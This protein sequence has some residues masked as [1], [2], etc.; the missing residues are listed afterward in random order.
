[1]VGETLEEAAIREVKEETGLDVEIDGVF[2]VSE[3]FFVER[4]HH[5]IFFTFRGKIIGR[6]INISMPKEIEEITWI[7]SQKAED[8]IHITNSK[9]L[10]KSKSSVPYLL[11]KEL[12]VSPNSFFMKRVL[13]FNRYC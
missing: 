12:F 8:Y 11:K 4:G 1:M 13:L 9:G 6:E 2:S 10:I 3:A 7:D 5:A